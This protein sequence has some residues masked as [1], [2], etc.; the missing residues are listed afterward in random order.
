MD[1]ELITVPDIHIGNIILDYLNKNRIS[2]AEL[3]RGLKLDASYLHRLLLKKSMETSRLLE[4]CIVLDY[5]FF[6]FFCND[7]KANEKG[8]SFGPV[9]I[10]SN[11]EKRLK[12]IEMTQTEF[13][14]KLGVSQSE[15]SR[16]LK[17]TSFETDKLSYIS[18]I[19]GYN[20]FKDFYHVYSSEQSNDLLSY[21]KIMERYDEVIIENDRLKQKLLKLEEENKI[22]KEENSRL[23]G[24]LI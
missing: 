15:V 17:K 6:T 14:S 9:E 3:A 5:N 12:E 4:I 19:L 18:H 11:I 10:G 21:T 1:L 20:F 22:L 16:L 2:K 8:T 7:S 23:K 13:A 24:T